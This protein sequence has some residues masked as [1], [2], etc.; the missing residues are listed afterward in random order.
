MSTA[1]ATCSPAPIPHDAVDGV[2]EQIRSGRS[3]TPG[4]FQRSSQARIFFFTSGIYDRSFDVSADSADCL[5]VALR[6][7]HRTRI[8]I[9]LLFKQQE[10]RPG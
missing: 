6:H 7:A 5:R 8:A 3:I 4:V 9:L 1:R 10:N 2:L